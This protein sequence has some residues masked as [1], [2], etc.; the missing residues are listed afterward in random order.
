VR[1]DVIG[2]FMGYEIWLESILGVGTMWLVS[3]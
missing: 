3:G 2:D 1:W